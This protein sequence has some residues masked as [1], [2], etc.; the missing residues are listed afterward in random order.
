MRSREQAA[1]YATATGQS[2]KIRRGD[3][4]AKGRNKRMADQCRLA[5]NLLER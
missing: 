5:R 1:E 4:S 3:F 2:A